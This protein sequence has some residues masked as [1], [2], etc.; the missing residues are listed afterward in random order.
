MKLIIALVA[1]LLPAGLVGLAQSIDLTEID[2]LRIENRDLKRQLVVATADIAQWQ[3][4]FGVCAGR[5]GE[6]E[7]A[8]NETAL[9]QD[10]VR[11]KLAIEAAHPGFTW[12]TDTLVPMTPK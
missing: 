10:D 12:T 2:R 1:L 6:L 11:L 5:R 3:Q 9:K 7:R 8:Q 4:A